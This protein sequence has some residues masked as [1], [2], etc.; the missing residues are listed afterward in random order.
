MRRCGFEALLN[1]DSYGASQ[2]F[3]IERRQ[4]GGNGIVYNSV[5]NPGGQCVAAFWPDVPAIP[6]P[7]RHFRY[8]PFQ[9]LRSATHGTGDG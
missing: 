1:P 8:H 4:A 6:V 5:R 2:A 3:A 9:L 7:C